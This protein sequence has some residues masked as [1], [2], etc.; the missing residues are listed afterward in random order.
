MMERYTKREIAD[1]H[2]A[3]ALALFIEMTTTCARSRLPGQRTLR[4]R[5]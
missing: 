4:L 3:R 2:L 5:Q 1:A